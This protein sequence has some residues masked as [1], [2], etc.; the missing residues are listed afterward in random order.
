MS[1]Q[2]MLDGKVIVVTGACR[3]IGR[4]IAMLIADR[5]AKVVVRW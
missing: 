5:G 4:A 1:N 2:K 3:G